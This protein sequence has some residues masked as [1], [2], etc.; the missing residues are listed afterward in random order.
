MADNAELKIVILWADEIKQAGIA[1]DNLN[2]VLADKKATQK[3]VDTAL[4]SALGAC[5][6]ALKGVGSAQST[7]H[8]MLCHG[9]R[10]KLLPR[11]IT[12][13]RESKT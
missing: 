5:M 1:L 13:V 6:V 8:M 12:I 10:V 3:A 11:N 9:D 4:K 7:A 2:A